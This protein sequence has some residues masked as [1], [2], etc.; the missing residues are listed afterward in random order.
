ML[1]KYGFQVQST[2]IF[3]A[4]GINKDISGA[5]H[6][7]ICRTWII[8]VIPGAEHRNIKSIVLP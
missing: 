3:V 4:T 5:E 2:V 8:L 1:L 7:H 6:R